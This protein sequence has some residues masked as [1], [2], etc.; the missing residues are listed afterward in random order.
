[1][2]NIK[3][4]DSSLEEGDISKVLAQ[5]SAALRLGYLSRLHPYG[6]RTQTVPE[7]TH[8]ADACPNKHPSTANACA[9]MAEGCRRRGYAFKAFS[10]AAP[11][12]AELMPSTS[13]DFSTPNSAVHTVRTTQGTSDGGLCS[14]R[15]H[16]R[17][18]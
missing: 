18:R 4:V 14:S 11:K 8:T 1:M 15:A 9:A 6:R 7:P 12:S 13:T 2:K 16:R 3:L 17:W 5:R 10:R